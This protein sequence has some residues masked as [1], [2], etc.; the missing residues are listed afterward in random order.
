MDWSRNF[1]LNHWPCVF[2]LSLFLLLHHHLF[3]AFS[4]CLSYLSNYLDVSRGRWVEP[5]NAL[6]IAFVFFLLR[7]FHRRVR[8]SSRS[9]NRWQEKVDG[10]RD[11]VC[12]TTRSIF[13]AWSDGPVGVGSIRFSVAIH[14]LKFL[15]G[16]SLFR[17]EPAK[18]CPLVY[19]VFQMSNAYHSVARSRVPLEIAQ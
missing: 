7:P 9:G 4:I 12:C 1:V 2:Q 6:L 3:S 19:L 13:I 15:F 10:V 11:G 8:S 14:P 5:S 16:S 17:F 18:V